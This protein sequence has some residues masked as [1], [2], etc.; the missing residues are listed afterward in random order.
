[1]L[2]TIYI[3]TVNLPG[4]ELNVF[5]GILDNRFEVNTLWLLQNGPGST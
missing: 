2:F 5:E 4:L 1:M 3:I